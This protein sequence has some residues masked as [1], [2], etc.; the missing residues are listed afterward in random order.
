LLNLHQGKNHKKIEQW[1]A[2]YTASLEH[3]KKWQPSRLPDNVKVSIRI[4]RK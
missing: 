1:I 2:C 4:L 3:M